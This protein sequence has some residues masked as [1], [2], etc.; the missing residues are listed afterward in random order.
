MLKKT[1]F[2]VIFFLAFGASPLFSQNF[3]DWRIHRKMVASIA[4]GNAGYTG[5]LNGNNKAWNGLTMAGIGFRYNIYE[6]YSARAELNYYRISGDDADAPLGSFGNQSRNLSFFANNLEI[7]VEAQYDL[8]YNGGWYYQRSPVVPYIFAGV[9]FTYS[10]PK[11]KLDGQTYS[12][13]PVQTEGESYSALPLILPVGIGVRYKVNYLFDIG[14]EMAYRFMFTDYLDDVSG[15]YIDPALFANEV[16]RRLADRRS[17]LGLDPAMGGDGRGNPDI[18]DGY[19]YISL[20]L[21]YY[22][23]RDFFRRS[24][25]GVPKIKPF[26]KFKKKLHAL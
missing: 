1:H 12:L 19:G 6:R 21:S 22:L 25:R 11:A 24:S 14:L 17:E 18:N 23:P 13:R 7:M 20:R 3:Y 2:F 8:I 9:G 10:S 4:L 26:R 15:F 16:E 5:E